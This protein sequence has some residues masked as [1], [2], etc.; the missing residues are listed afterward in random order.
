MDWWNFSS[1]N[2]MD[3]VMVLLGVTTACLRLAT[4]ATYYYAGKTMYVLTGAFI[5]LRMFRLYSVSPRLGPK[6]VMIKKMVVELLL[7]VCILAVALLTYGICSQSLLYPIRPF[8]WQAMKLIFYYPYWQVYGE[9]YLEAANG[10]C[11]LSYIRNAFFETY[12]YKR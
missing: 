4:G 9:I 11:E 1:W 12:G 2:R 5:F 8:S 3:V 6:L 7:Y 10:E